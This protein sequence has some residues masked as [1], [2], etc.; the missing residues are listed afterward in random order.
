MDTDQIRSR[1]TRS[2]QGVDIPNQLG[3]G[4]GE[5]DGE[6]PPGKPRDQGVLYERASCGLP[7]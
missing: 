1:D 5:D 7:T 6:G 3:Q 4:Y 2:R